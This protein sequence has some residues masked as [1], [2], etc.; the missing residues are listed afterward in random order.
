MDD[1]QHHELKALSIVLFNGNDV[2]GN[3]IS[4]VEAQNVV[5]HMNRPFGALWTH[6]GILVDR[7]I[8]P[9]D[10]LQEGKLY[11]YE[12][13][14]S[15]KV[16]GYEYSKVLCVDHEDKH[17][18]HLG[19]QIRDFAAVVDE[20][21]SDV[22]IFPL[23]PALHGKIMKD[24]ENTRAIM[25][26]FYEKYKTWSYP[27]NP[28]A[29]F[30]AA[31]PALYNSITTMKFAVEKITETANA[32]AVKMRGQA[33][34]KTPPPGSPNAANNR[35][36]ASNHIPA[37]AINS[38]L[39]SLANIPDVAVP[40]RSTSMSNIPTPAPAAVASPKQGFK[41]P[42]GL[43]KKD[44]PEAAP[45]AVAAQEAAAAAAVA[46]S[47]TVAR[48]E[49]E[50]RQV[51]CSEMVAL[52]CLS[53]NMPDFA[54]GPTPA[55]I[56]PLELNDM[57]CYAANWFYVKVG[58]ENLLEGAD[59]RRS[60]RVDE[61][62]IRKE[63]FKGLDVPK[64][65]RW[66]IGVTGNTLPKGHKENLATDP[67]GNP[68]YVGRVALGT[69]T[70]IGTTDSEGMLSLHYEGKKV[71]ITYPHDILWDVRGTCWVKPEKGQNIPPN[72]LV[73]GA[74]ENGKPIYIAKSQFLEKGVGIM[75]LAIGPRAADKERVIFGSAQAEKEGAMFAVYGKETHVKE[76][77]WILCSEE[78]K[79]EEVL[80]EWY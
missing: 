4:K 32:A 10:C 74:D 70:T 78:G 66:L 29:Q 77:Y 79:H 26:A 73:G 5:P 50:S 18:F 71:K 42:F 23:E 58:G 36:T 43:S 33:I 8:L 15:G 68:I 1:R 48:A 30:A 80:K 75:G 64:G 57:D 3:F 16:L 17:G 7:S 38:R 28:L 40:N 39:S 12:S 55:E 56:T 69:M 62:R 61:D 53:L 59:G 63:I 19:P 35:S 27:L 31:S 21:T 46:V 11:L 51:F 9:L 44:V 65:Q 67:S 25:M 47:P 14:F 45:E 60:R 37:E 13:I 22:A 49:R 52:L 2:V 24:I 54:K 34:G 6:A 72:A 41:F 20:V 76:G